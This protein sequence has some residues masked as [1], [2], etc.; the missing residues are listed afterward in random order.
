MAF[1]YA[2]KLSELAAK[3]AVKVSVSGRSV[4][5]ARMGDE[6]YATSANCPH[7][8]VPMR[9][10]DVT[11]QGVV[12]CWFHGAQF[13]IR[14]GAVMRPPLSQAWR[15]TIPLG[16]GQVAAAIIPS[17]CKALG[18]YNVQL[19]GQEVWVNAGS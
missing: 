16:M 12:T 1:E 11:E 6:I 2:I 4:I 14:S 5:V 3:A 9:A 15:K 13:D 18:L 7:L 8:G 17:G 10:S 19:R